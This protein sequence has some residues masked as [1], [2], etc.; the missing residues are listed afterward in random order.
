MLINRFVYNFSLPYYC[1][2]D[3]A[4]INLQNDQQIS[5]NDRQYFY[6]VR[7]FEITNI[8]GTATTVLQEYFIANLFSE[9]YKLYKTKRWQLV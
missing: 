7:P 8:L 1:E 4:L 3:A 5:I 9:H 6:S 2:T